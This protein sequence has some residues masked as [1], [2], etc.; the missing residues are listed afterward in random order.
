MSMVGAIATDS[1]VTGL[2]SRQTGLD[3]GENDV[4]SQA[5]GLDR[6]LAPCG[7]HLV[8]MSNPTIV[9]GDAHL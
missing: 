5:T 9:R 6:P 1:P 3:S 4:D 8:H 7:F 2:V